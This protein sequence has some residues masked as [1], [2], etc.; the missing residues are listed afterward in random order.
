MFSSETGRI[1]EMAHSS[2]FPAGQGC[3]VATAVLCCSLSFTVLFAVNQSPTNKL[4]PRWSF[5]ISSVH[6]VTWLLTLRD[7]RRRRAFDGRDCLF[8]FSMDQSTQSV[9]VLFVLSA[10]LALSLSLSLY[11]QYNHMSPFLF[12]CIRLDSWCLSDSR[13]AYVCADATRVRR[14]MITVLIG[15]NK[16][17]CNVQP[18]NVGPISIDERT[19]TYFCGGEKRSNGTESCMV[20]H[21]H[22]IGGCVELCNHAGC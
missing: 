11:N 9:I 1:S 17:R 19:L 2:S 18:T 20:V 3:S 22:S 7:E 6:G 21:N 4:S 15:Q 5:P 10:G 8:L 14:P 16:K 13:A 12:R